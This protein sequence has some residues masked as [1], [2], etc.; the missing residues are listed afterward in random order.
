VFYEYII[1]FGAEVAVVWKRKVRGGPLLLLMTRYA[2]VTLAAIAL[3]PVEHLGPTA[4]RPDHDRLL[5]NM[6]S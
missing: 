5:C 6:T 4:I 1:T 3:V 2:M